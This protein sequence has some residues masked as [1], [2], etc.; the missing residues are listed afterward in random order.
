MALPGF[1]STVLQRGDDLVAGRQT[2]GRNDIGELAVLVFHQCDPGGA[3]GIV[4]QPLDRA[5]GVELGALEIDHAVRALVP[6]AA[7][8]RGDAA[9]VVAAAVLVQAF[10]QRLDRLALPQL[11]PIG[12]DELAAARRRSDCR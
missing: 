1:T 3:V 7:M 5:D 12:R 9:G 2:L 11:R 4:F 8:V 6:A 10:G